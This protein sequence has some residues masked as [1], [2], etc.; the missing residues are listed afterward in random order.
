MTVRKA[1]SWYRHS[2]DTA[3]C[4]EPHASKSSWGSQA[5]PERSGGAED[6]VWR[7]EKTMRK[8][9]GNKGLCLAGDIREDSGVRRLEEH[10]AV[11]GSGWGRV[12]L[13]GV[14]AACWKLRSC[15][16]SRWGRVR[17]RWRRAAPC[18]V[19]MSSEVMVYML[20]ST[21]SCWQEYVWALRLFLFGINLG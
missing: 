15:R 18:P 10:G 19:F 17:R 16:W 4:P 1:M 9:K 7:V 12:E 8:Q 13:E 21:F 6:L 20:P 2:P 5:G 11:W 14:A 3:L